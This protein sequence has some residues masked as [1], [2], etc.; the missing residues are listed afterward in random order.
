M[1]RCGVKM[2]VNPDFRDLFCAFNDAEVRF[3]VVG[4]Y[5]VIH[6]TEPRYTKDIDLW[7]ERT[8][9]NA[10]RTLQALALFG[11]PVEGVSAADFQDP[12]TVYQIGIE[13]NRVDILVQIAGVEFGAAYTGAVEASYG[14]VAIRILSLEDV[15]SAKRAAGRDQDLLDLKR[16][17]EA[18]GRT[19]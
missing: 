9:I 12:D 3:L 4:A 10:A 6:Y 14:D 13:P 1:K 16:L 7:I 5:A 15:I 17:L 8:P 18:K 2:A 19:R 11:A